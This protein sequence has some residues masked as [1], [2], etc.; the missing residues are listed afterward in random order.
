MEIYLHNKTYNGSSQINITYDNITIYGGNSAGD[1]LSST[2]D[3]KGLC[4]IMYLS[5]SVKT[6]TFVNIKFINGNADNGGAI[7]VDSD[8]TIFGV[9]TSFVGNNATDRGGAIYVY[10]GGSLCISG[11]NTSFN[12]NCARAK[13][14]GRRRG[15]LCR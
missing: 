15:C 1:G 11:V 3:A 5:N 14:L 10:N 6:I 7:Y 12:D 13:D 4:R 2:L 8:V 9:N